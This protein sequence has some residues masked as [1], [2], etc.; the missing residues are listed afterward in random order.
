MLF[1]GSDPLPAERDAVGLRKT[2]T[3]KQ[4]AHRATEH[5]R[6]ADGNSVQFNPANHFALRR[7]FAT[8]LARAGRLGHWS[9]ARKFMAELQFLDA[10]AV[11]GSSCVSVGPPGNSGIASSDAVECAHVAAGRRGAH[12]LGDPSLATTTIP[13]LRREVVS[14]RTGRDGPSHPGVRLERPSAG[15]G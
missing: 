6:P 13:E 8:R 10:A 7:S 1:A 9:E 2:S 12:S 5:P 4:P 15:P 11:A 3:D 14:R